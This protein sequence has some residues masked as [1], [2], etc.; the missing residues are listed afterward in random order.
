MRRVLGEELA[1]QPV[2]E[3]QRSR[4]RVSA[5][6]ELEIA[7]ICD[8]A[9]LQRSRTRVSAESSISFGVDAGRFAT[10]TEPHSCECGE[11]CEGFVGGTF[12][13]NFNGAALV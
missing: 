7:G 11:C 1:L 6:R 12:S 10:S 5:E 9:I 4:T 13:V 8:R 2:V 3:L